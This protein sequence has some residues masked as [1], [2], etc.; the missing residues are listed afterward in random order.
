ML[1][2]GIKYAVASEIQSKSCVE[3]VGAYKSK[4]FVNSCI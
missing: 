2:L 3:F 1:E 4:A